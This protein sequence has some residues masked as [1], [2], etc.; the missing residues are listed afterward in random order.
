MTTTKNISGASLPL[1]DSDK[2]PCQK[3]SP[4]LARYLRGRPAAGVSGFNKLPSLFPAQVQDWAHCWRSLGSPGWWLFLK[5][6]QEECYSVDSVWPLTSIQSNVR[7]LH[8]SMFTLHFSI[9][10]MMT[11]GQ[12]NVSLRIYLFAYLKSS[13]SKCITEP[14]CITRDVEFLSFPQNNFVKIAAKTKRDSLCVC[15]CSHTS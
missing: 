15:P 12:S 1:E 4:Y 3:I 14:V 6:K 2:D 8:Q 11:N 9:F 13:F 10:I 7:T 5:D